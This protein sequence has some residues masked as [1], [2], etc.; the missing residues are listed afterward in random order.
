MKRLTFV[1]VGLLGAACG[2]EPAE[3]VA[4]D[5]AVVDVDASAATVDAVFGG[6]AMFGA[7]PV[8]PPECTGAAVPPLSLVC[9]GLYADIAAKQIAGNVRAY[10]PAVALWSDGAEKHRWIA[11]PA[12]T[13]I[14]TTDPNEWSFPIG[15]K[16]WKEFV[17]DG[18]RVETR[19]W[20]KVR[21][22]FWV[23]AAYAWNADESVAMKSP[24][25]DIALP[26]GGTYHIPTGAECDKCHRG[27]TENILG[28]EQVSLGL[29]GAS[30]L[31]LAEL[32][33]QGL[34]TAPPL[35]TSLSIGDD[36]TGAAAPA[37]AWIHINCG[38]TCHN[39][40]PNATA[41]GAGMRLR[42]DPLLLDGRSVSDFD[43]LKTTQGIAV[44]A[45]AWNGRVRIIPGDPERSLLY[46][47]IS[48]RGPNVQM[49][50]IAS[51]VVDVV[52]V[53]RIEAW[54]Q[55]MHRAPVDAGSDVG[56]DAG[57][58]DAGSDASASADVANPGARD[59]SLDAP[60]PEASL[61]DQHALPDASEQLP[62]GSVA[63]DAGSG[64]DADASAADAASAS[65]GAPSG[66]DGG[67][68][69]PDASEPGEA[70]AGAGEPPDAPDGHIDAPV[71]DPEAPDSGSADA[72]GGS[73]YPSE[74]S[75]ASDEGGSTSP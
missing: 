27:R 39:R 42:L 69:A 74:P 10:A 35:S 29:Q 8:L 18:R 30:G 15:T 64:V 32:V 28:F 52:N 38:V 65:D 66:S 54:I 68:E 25:G 41:Y 24:G 33:K 23:A 16:F 49:P 3:P 67:V 47:L 53:A 36:G 70:D 59:A 73:A 46:S 71:I 55:A 21:D 44:N 1:V 22:R 43:P 34:L 56:Y 31:T 2:S 48:H 5:A 72:D 51:N 14:D 37:L 11:L 20:Q 61:A 17:R 63:S 19:L 12:G 57:S 6:G 26:A 40:N 7:A 4:A 45:P 62:D 58:E 9:T 60:T 13:T 50:P 75:G